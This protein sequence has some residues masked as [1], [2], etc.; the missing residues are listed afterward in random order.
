MCVGVFNNKNDLNLELLS[1]SWTQK[2]GE[3]A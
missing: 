1:F 3:S 2:L